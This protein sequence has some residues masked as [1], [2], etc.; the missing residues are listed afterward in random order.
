MTRPLRNERPAQKHELLHPACLPSLLPAREVEI[1]DGLGANV[2]PCGVHDEDYL[3]AGIRDFSDSVADGVDVGGEGLGVW[4]A[5]VSA[6][7]GDY[8]G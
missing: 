5:G 7:E 3:A 4:A 6:G 1:F 8:E 2:C